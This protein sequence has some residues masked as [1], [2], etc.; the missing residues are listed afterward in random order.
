MSSVFPS[1]HQVE[2]VYYLHFNVDLRIMCQGLINRQPAGTF[3]YTYVHVPEEEAARELR[4]AMELMPGHEPPTAQPQS[5]PQGQKSRHRLSVEA[6]KEPA[7]GNVRALSG[8]GSRSIAPRLH[9]RFDVTFHPLQSLRRPSAEGGAQRGLARHLSKSS[10][11]SSSIGRSSI[12]SLMF[13]FGSIGGGSTN[14]RGSS[15]R[16]SSLASTTSG[17]LQHVLEE[18]EPPA[19]D[20]PP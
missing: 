13:S 8:V 18:E 16:P 14:S 15:G 2:G 3:S 10:S 5:P 7:A 6:W 20:R 17:R 1:S 9:V 12:R 11:Q 19:A 4:A